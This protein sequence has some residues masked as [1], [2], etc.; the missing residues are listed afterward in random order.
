[1]PLTAKAREIECENRRYRHC[2]EMDE[3]SVK[4]KMEG[5]EVF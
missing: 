4:E 2:G 1:M 3:L 5:E